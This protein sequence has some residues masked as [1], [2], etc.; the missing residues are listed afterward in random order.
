MGACCEEIERGMES[1]LEVKMAKIYYVDVE[2]FQTIK[3]FSQI[4]SFKYT[5]KSRRWWWWSPAV[6]VRL[7]QDHRRLEG[8]PTI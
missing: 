1:G 3:I 8:K 5:F 2:N 7:G 4:V 6:S